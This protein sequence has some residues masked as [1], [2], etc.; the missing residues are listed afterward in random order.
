MTDL[1]MWVVTENP[2]DF[3]GQFVAREWLIGSGC[4]A[5]TANHHV[6]ATLAEVRDMLPPLLHRLP[7]DPKDDPVIVECWI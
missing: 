2:T 7:R 4:R 6:A 1:S 5:V 3:P